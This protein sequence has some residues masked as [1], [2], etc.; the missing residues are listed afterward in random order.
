MK[1]HLAVIIAAVLLCGCAGGTYTDTTT[2]Y[3]L[4]VKLAADKAPVIVNIG[5]M[6]HDRV[7]LETNTTA[8][9]TLLKATDVEQLSWLRQRVHTV[10]AVGKD[11][12][13][14]PSASAHMAP[15][16][17]TPTGAP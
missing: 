5:M 1:T 12:V 8:S 15:T 16:Q 14:Q 7:E 11:A 6:R 17:Q 3:G 13:V 2:A 10:T 4:N 9:T